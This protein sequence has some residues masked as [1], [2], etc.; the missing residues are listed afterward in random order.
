MSMEIGSRILKLSRRKLSFYEKL[1]GT[2]F[3]NRVEAATVMSDLVTARVPFRVT[4]W[5][6]LFGN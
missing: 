2:S 5:P 4:S 3:P 1:L 6:Y